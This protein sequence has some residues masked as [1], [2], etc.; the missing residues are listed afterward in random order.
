MK[1]SFLDLMEKTLSAY[2]KE[3]IISYF[4]NVKQN[5]LK[6]HGFP[7]L[8]CNIGILIKNGRCKELLPHFIEMMDFCCQNIPLVKAA[9]DFSVREIVCCLQELEV[10]P[11]IE[12]EKLNKWKENIS[13]INP[14][15][16][17]SVYATSES[18]LVHNWALFTAVSEYFRLTAGLGGDMDFIELQLASQMKRLDKNGMYIDWEL[19]ANNQAMVYD[20]VPRMLFCLLL[21]RGYR[22]KYFTQI[23]NALKKAG[24]ATLKMQSVSGEIPFGGRSNMFLHNEATLSCVLEYEAE[25]YYLLGNFSLAGKFKSASNLAF[26]SIKYW[27]NKPLITHVKNNFDLNTLFGCEDYAYFDKYMITLSSFIYASSLLCNNKIKPIKDNYLSLFTT[28]KSFNK[29]FAKVGGYFVQINTNGDNC[30]DS[31][32]IGRIHKK[33][34]PPIICLSM[35]FVEHP[36]YVT[37]QNYIG[38]SFSICPVIINSENNLEFG[39]TLNVAYKLKEKVIKPNS[40]LLNYNCVFSGK[41]KGQLILKISKNGVSLK[42]KSKTENNIGIA[43]AAFKFDGKNYSEIKQDNKSLSV[44][45][46]GYICNYSG[47]I[48]CLNK[49][50]QNRNGIYL[51]YMSKGNKTAKLNVKIKKVKKS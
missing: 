11:L 5:G 33:G 30:Y 40:I 4:N 18:D 22:G 48:V 44:S 45:Y 13:K 9:N 38:H 51:A 32:G 1:K 16:C 21:K 43:F 23:D 12:K 24:L 50:L 20:L 17:Y 10:C 14:K 42:A 34:A 37:E 39:S 47:N 26:N 6:E 2:S 27:L 36:H 29:T 49:E 19:N 3:Q 31:S 35:P 41:I 28:S 15:T 25:R 7:R 8:T 46:Q